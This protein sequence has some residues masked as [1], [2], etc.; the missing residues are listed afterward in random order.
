M[1][2][3]GKFIFWCAFIACGIFWAYFTSSY[4]FKN[5]RWIIGTLWAIVGFFHFL[6]YQYITVSPIEYIV[7][8]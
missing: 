4:D 6:L 1:T 7:Y 2:E 3:L 8:G 5:G